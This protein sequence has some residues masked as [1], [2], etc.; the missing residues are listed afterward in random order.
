VTEQMNAR[1]QRWEFFAMP[2]HQSWQSF[3]IRVILKT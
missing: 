1:S 3:L 2:N